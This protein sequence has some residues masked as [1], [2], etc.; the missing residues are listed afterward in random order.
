[1]ISYHNHK[2]PG[3]VIRHAVM[4]DAAPLPY[5]TVFE[6]WVGQTDCLPFGKRKQAFDAAMELYNNKRVILFQA[7]V[8]DGF[9]YRAKVI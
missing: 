3:R 6:Y 5:G 1:M 4:D 8:D 9:S 2:E 7:R